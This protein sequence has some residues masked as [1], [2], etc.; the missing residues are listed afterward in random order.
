MLTCALL[1]LVGASI[2]AWRWRHQAQE[3]I[4]VAMPRV[5]ASLAASDATPRQ[6]LSTITFGQRR[7]DCFTTFLLYA[8]A[9][10]RCPLLSIMLF[11]QAMKTIAIT[12]ANASVVAVIDTMNLTRSTAAVG[13]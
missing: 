10:S 12:S 3:K 9:G 13:M 5:G 2:S 6:G 8:L 7:L 11:N 4:V 1:A